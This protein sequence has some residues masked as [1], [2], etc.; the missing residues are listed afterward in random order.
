MH[1]LYDSNEVDRSTP[2]YPSM[3][4]V[5]HPNLQSPAGQYLL[6]YL[7]AQVYVS[8]DT[9]YGIKPVPHGKG[10]ID[11]WPVVSQTPNPASQ[12]VALLYQITPQPIIS[13][14]GSQGRL[15]QLMHQN[16]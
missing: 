11:C 4:P 9:C 7:D 12:V 15:L 10:R 3:S 13:P 5:G 14:C 16:A 6:Q 8:N 1:P 2:S